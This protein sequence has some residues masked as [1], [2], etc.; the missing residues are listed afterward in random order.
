MFVE[1]DVWENKSRRGDDLTRSGNKV[2]LCIDGLCALLR[3]KRKW[4]AA[5]D[6]SQLSGV[7]EKSITHYSTWKTTYMLCQMVLFASSIAT[8]CT[9]MIEC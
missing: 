5:M 2:P 7:I 8:L 3:I 6:W 4:V 1:Y 9:S